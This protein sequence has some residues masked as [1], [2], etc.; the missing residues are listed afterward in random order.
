MNPC[1]IFTDLLYS[2]FNIS[3]LGYLF[4][5]ILWEKYLS[6]VEKMGGDC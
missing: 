2:Y 4:I 3:S 1:S 5:S 6:R